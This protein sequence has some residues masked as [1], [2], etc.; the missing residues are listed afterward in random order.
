LGSPWGAQCAN[1]R[2]Q[3]PQ[4]RSVGKAVW[5]SPE[6]AAKKNDQGCY[7]IHYNKL[8]RVFKAPATFTRGIQPTFPGGSGILERGPWVRCVCGD[9]SKGTST[10]SVPF[11]L[12]LAVRAYLNLDAYVYNLGPPYHERR[13]VCTSAISTAWSSNKSS[14]SCQGKPLLLN[15]GTLEKPLADK[16]KRLVPPAYAF[17]ARPQDRVPFRRPRAMHAL[18]ASILRHPDDRSDTAATR[19][20]LEDL[21]DEGNRAPQRFTGRAKLFVA[22][23]DRD[24]Y[25]ALWP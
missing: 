17:R 15:L 22:K 9:A 14:Y 20:L 24:G 1:A 21:T 13:V 5:T 23:C 19:R 2:Q 8:E 10:E 16:Q 3:P 25:T 11:A 4:S 18:C 7:V 6:T 12:L